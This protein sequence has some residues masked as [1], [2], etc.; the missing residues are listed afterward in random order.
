VVRKKA[1]REQLPAYECQQCSSFYSAL[2]SWGVS[3]PGGQQLLA[4]PTC[5]H[6]AKASAAAAAAGVVAVGVQG[7]GGGAAAAAGTA[8]TVGGGGE[9]GMQQQQQ[10]QQQGG[11]GLGQQG[12][13][14]QNGR[15][16]ARWQ[17]PSTPQGFWNMGFG[18]DPSTQDMGHK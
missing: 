3:G 18:D 5:G 9:G 1:V 13:L 7:G 12:W 6:A 10:Q 17:P 14:Q 16:R 2:S 15:H 8:G 11:L 4:L